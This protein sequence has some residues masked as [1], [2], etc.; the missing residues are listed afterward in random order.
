[1]PATKKKKP[2]PS[3]SVAHKRAGH[4]NIMIWLTKADYDTIQNAA[5]AANS[6]ISQFVAWSALTAAQKNP[7]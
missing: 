7:K 4:R 5:L 1:M 6:P 2:N 3:S